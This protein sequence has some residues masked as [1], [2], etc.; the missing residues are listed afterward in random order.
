MS[1]LVARVRGGRTG[2]IYEVHTCGDYFIIGTQ[3]EEG[4]DI[5]GGRD[6][7]SLETALAWIRNYEEKQP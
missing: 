5:L 7:D 3:A 6:F 2:D 4:V 1:T